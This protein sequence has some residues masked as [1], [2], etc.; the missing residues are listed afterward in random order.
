MTQ[1]ERNELY[2]YYTDQVCECG[3]D[4]IDCGDCIAPEAP[5]GWQAP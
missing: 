4:Y 5:E 1:E 2:A 3:I